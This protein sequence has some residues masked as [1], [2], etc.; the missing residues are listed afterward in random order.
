MNIESCLLGSK[1]YDKATARYRNITRKL[2]IFIGTINVPN[3][4]VS[5]DEFEDFIKE[6]NPKYIVPGRTVMNKELDL[7]MQELKSKISTRLNEAGKIARAYSITITYIIYVTADE[8]M[9][10][11]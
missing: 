7:L 10:H 6:L 2:A 9:C 3:S 4:I 1:P 11:K 8:K 5:N